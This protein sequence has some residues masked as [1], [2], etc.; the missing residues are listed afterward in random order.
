MRQ[1]S[2]HMCICTSR[3]KPAETLGGCAPNA[4]LKFKGDSC[5]RTCSR[6]RVDVLITIGDLNGRIAYDIPDTPSHPERNSD[7]LAATNLRGKDFL[8][9]ASDNKLFILNGVT[10]LGATNG[11]KTSFQSRSD[12]SRSSVI[13]YC[14]CSE[15][16]L[17]LVSGFS[18]GQRDSWLVQREIGSG[19]S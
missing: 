17:Q 3:R 10:S 13:D 4:T 1:H 15:D 19:P 6:L 18:I 14:L 7:N 5:R 12:D 11:T 8:Q 9:F 2:S 16:V